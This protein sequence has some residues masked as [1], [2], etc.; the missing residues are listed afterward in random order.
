MVSQVTPAQ[1]LWKLIALITFA[2]SLTAISQASI[3]GVGGT[4]PPTPLTPSGSILA[5]TS[6][7][8]TTPTFS[9]DYVTWVYADPTNTWCS[10]CLDF[11]YQFTDNGPHPNQRYS[12][13]SFSGFNV[14]AGTSPFGVHDPNTVSRSVLLSGDVVSFNFDQF[15]NDIQPG[16][17]TVL[18]VIETNAMNFAPGFLSA[19]DGTAGSGV[20]FQPAGPAVPEPASLML[21]GSGLLA[22]GGFLR[23]TRGR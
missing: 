14:D 2:L 5:M 3:L 12:M 4:A 8:I 7:N 21:L 22:V 1:R 6:G 9:T 20:A 15:G 23:K 11:V 17:T 13:S 10:G 18:L 19:Q 16:E